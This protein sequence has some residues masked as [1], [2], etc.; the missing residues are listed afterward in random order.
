MKIAI[1]GKFSRIYDEEQIALS[2]EQLGVD[3]VRIRDAINVPSAIEIIR[4][5]TPDVVLYF[6]LD[7]VG[8][9]KVL[10]DWLKSK[11]IK[12]VCWLFDLYRVGPRLIVIFTS[13]IFTSDFVFTT[14][15]G[16]EE[17][18]KRNGINHHLLRQGI[19]GKFTYVAEQC[20]KYKHDV[21][22]VG[23]RNSWW[24]YRKKV[25]GFLR[26]KYG[27]RFVR[28]GE[29]DTHEIRTDELNKLYSSAKIIIGD[30]VYS[31]GYWSNRIY[32]TIGRGGFF[33]HP[34]VE[35]LDKEFEPYKEFIPYNF[36]DFDG[37]KEKIDYY[38]IH[39]DERNK[40][41]MAGFE[42]CKKDYTYVNRCRDLIKIVCKE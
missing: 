31:P 8:S 5:E 32:E 18:W 38:L 27:D 1:I 19:Y 6:K 10:I 42:R 20:K 34:M 37:L 36:N 17:I 13:P 28:Y 35:G 21:V 23:G 39:D 16:D 30:S 11:G 12:T 2:F 15:G 14:D 40:I 7:I 33:I 26:S 4:N 41:R 9:Q 24:G 22:F 3:V 25:M 29:K